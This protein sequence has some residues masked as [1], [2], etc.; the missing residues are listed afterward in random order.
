MQELS[1]QAELALAMEYSSVDKQ[2]QSPQEPK[3]IESSIHNNLLKCYRQEWSFGRHC[4]SNF[5][6]DIPAEPE[7]LDADL[8]PMLSALGKAMGALSEPDRRLIEMLYWLQRKES[9]IA[10][11]MGVSQPAISK[12]KR[13][14]LSKLSTV[15]KNNL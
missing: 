1:A 2:N 14:I 9:Q 10:A 15:M 13:L 11:E 7:V 3:R 12:R 5:T 6:P 4:C 8:G